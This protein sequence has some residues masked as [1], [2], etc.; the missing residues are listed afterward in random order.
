MPRRHALP[1]SWEQT[2]LAPPEV[3]EVRLRIGVIAGEDHM[4][5]QLEVMDPRTKELL[6]MEA[7]PAARFSNLADELP[8][9]G[10]R[11]WELLS[12]VTNPDPF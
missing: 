11:L 4:R 5:W 3:V 8:A 7:H 2:L 10:A 9:M 1:T 6:A 12:S